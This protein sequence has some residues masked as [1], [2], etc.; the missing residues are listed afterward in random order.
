MQQFPSVVSSKPAPHR[1]RR[2]WQIHKLSGEGGECPHGRYLAAQG[3][4]HGLPR[5]NDSSP[6]INNLGKC[7]ENFA[8]LHLRG[9]IE[10]KVTHPRRK[11]LKNAWLDVL[12]DRSR[13]EVEMRADLN[14]DGP[15][16]TKRS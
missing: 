15:H 5:A 10:E 4:N 3:A 6:A 8:N 1:G 2:G 9:R 13:L 14:R 7:C 12:H 16:S 11:V